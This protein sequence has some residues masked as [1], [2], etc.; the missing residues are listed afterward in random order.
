MRLMVPAEI[1]ASTLGLFSR[2]FRAVSG[3]RTVI[4]ELGNSFFREFMVV[5]SVL[6]ADLIRRIFL[7]LVVSFMS[8]SVVLIY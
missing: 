2:F 4:F 6:A 7:G 8:N 1:I 3:A 5:F